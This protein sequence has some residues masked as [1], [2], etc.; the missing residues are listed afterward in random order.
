MRFYPILDQDVEVLEERFPER[1]TRNFPD[2]SRVSTSN[3]TDDGLPFT[4]LDAS[5]PCDRALGVT[6][7]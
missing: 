7:I 1:P 3:F 2:F 5:S 6:F 4:E